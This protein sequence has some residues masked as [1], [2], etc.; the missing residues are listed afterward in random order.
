MGIKIT[1]KINVPRPAKV[2]P[3]FLIAIKVLFF[4]SK[5]PPLDVEWHE[6]IQAKKDKENPYTQLQSK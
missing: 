3:T 1:I 4:N 2:L 6:T 5:P